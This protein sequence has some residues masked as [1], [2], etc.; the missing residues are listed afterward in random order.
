[1]GLASPPAE[2]SVPCR[3]PRIDPRG[4]GCPPSVAGL[5]SAAVARECL[6]FRRS[7]TWRLTAPALKDPLPRSPPGASSESA[8]ALGY[9]LGVTG[10]RA[11]SGGAGGGKLVAPPTRRE[12]H[13][14]DV[15][16][17]ACFSS[18]PRWRAARGVLRHGSPPRHRMGC[19][20]LSFALLEVRGT[21]A[22]HS[23]PRRRLLGDGPDGSLSGI[24]ARIT[25]RRSR[26]GRQVSEP[27]HGNPRLLRRDARGSPRER[28]AGPPKASS[29]DHGGRNAANPETSPPYA[30]RVRR[31]RPGESIAHPQPGLVGPW[32]TVP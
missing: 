10:A 16:V 21:T 2:G 20:R 22:H 9:P 18:P 25:L 29:R 6:T 3:A 11:S 27:P 4:A 31:D 5:K 1:M 12:P 17:Q 30:Y 24:S 19:V 28:D 32:K 7:G 15:G 13:S 8:E 23:P 14:G 26:G